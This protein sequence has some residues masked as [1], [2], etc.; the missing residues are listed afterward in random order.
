MMIDQPTV[1]SVWPTTGPVRGKSMVTVYGTN[2]LNT[3]NLRCNFSEPTDGTWVS[4]SIIR[5]SSPEVPSPRF[6]SVE[7]TNNN[8]DYTS[9]M[10]AFEYQGN[11]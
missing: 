5:C 3:D 1:T 10:V 2:F 11:H 7:V 6:V 4:P 8:Q 9:S